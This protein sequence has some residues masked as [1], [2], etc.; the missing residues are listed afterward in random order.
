MPRKVGVLSSG[1]SEKVWPQACACFLSFSFLGC[2]A[3]MW[4]LSSPI[5]DC[6]ES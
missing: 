5:K 4:D 1:L 6:S 2:A 3:G